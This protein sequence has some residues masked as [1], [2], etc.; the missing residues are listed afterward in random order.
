M[1]PRIQDLHPDEFGRQVYNVRVALAIALLIILLVLSSTAYY[2]VA[3][4]EVG[5]VQRFG[6]F[7]KITQP[8]LNFKLPFGVDMVTKVPVLRQMKAE[9]GFRTKQADV[10]STFVGPKEDA[11]LR[12][13]A[14]MVTGDLNM[15]V[16]EWIIQYRIDDPEK[17]LFRMRDP[18]KT[19]M[20]ATESVMREVV[21]DRTVDEVLTFG[22]PEI[23]KQAQDKLQ[24]LVS[25]YEMGIGIKTVMLQIVTPP[26][27]V[28]DSFNE[29]SKA[30]QERERMI[31]EAR[32][33][34]N[35]VVPK[36]SGEALQKIQE[37]QGYNAK[38]VNEAMG[39]ATRFNAML[40]AYLKA[41][42]VTRRRIFLETMQSVIPKL[43]KKVVIDSDVK[44]MLPLL[45]VGTETEVVK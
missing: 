12:D 42:E 4:D 28:E 44:Q 21:G 34:Y 11:G 41:P 27:E 36:A 17:F 39:D 6:K 30:Q 35:K 31:Y 16:V 13:V 22:G 38:R 19:L 1:P 2:T 7:H 8:G 14:L 3:S 37:A 29:V 26:A 15:A 32:S 45:S 24:A 23:Q 40:T 43:G 18:E 5:V 20:D 33:E 9:F 10:R 25:K